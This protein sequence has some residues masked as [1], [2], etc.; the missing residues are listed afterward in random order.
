LT[1]RPEP[2]PEPIRRERHVEVSSIIEI[3]AVSPEMANRLKN[4]LMAAASGIRVEAIYNAQRA[5]M[6]IILVGSMEQNAAYFRLIAAI[7]ESEK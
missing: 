7:L 6:K 4:S 1:G 3:D 2:L 5:S